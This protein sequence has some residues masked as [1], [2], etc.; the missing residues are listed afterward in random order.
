LV[1]GLLLLRLPAK[2]D[3]LSSD[4]NVTEVFGAVHR[5]GVERYI[6][7]RGVN[8]LSGAS[9][10]NAGRQFNPADKPLREETMDTKRDTTE[11]TPAVDDGALEDAIRLRAYEI[12]QSADADTPEQNWERAVRELAPEN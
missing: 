6:E 12:S 7:F 11:E 4:L 9:A 8:S 10:T 1:V 5:D 2:P 3:H